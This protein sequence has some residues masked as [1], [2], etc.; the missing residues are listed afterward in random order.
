MS[1]SP[2][3]DALLSL[4]GRTASSVRRAR[5]RGAFGGLLVAAGTCVLIARLAA[6]AGLP[7]DALDAAH[8]LAAILIAVTAA[9]AFAWAG[10]PV[11]RGEAARRL[12]RHH[13]LRDAMASAAAFLDRSAPEPLERLHITRAAGVAAR[14]SLPR[15]T[16]PDRPW[17]MA[18]AVLWG[19]LGVWHVLPS[20][21]VSPAPD[22]VLAPERQTQSG[23]ATR[24]SLPVGSG[25]PAR[26]DPASTE[27]VD[28]VHRPAV[29][30]TSESGDAPVAPQSG[31]AAAPG[32]DGGPAASSLP[33]AAP[34]ANGG[35][36]GG[37]SGPD[38][39]A[40]RDDLARALAAL[41][42]DTA[43][44]R[45]DTASQGGV[46]L[47]P[48]KRPR[49]VES[50][51]GGS[52]A[53]RTHLAVD[54][55]PGAPQGEVAR[56]RQDGARGGSLPPPPSDGRWL[57]SGAAPDD[58]QRAVPAPASLG[59]EGG[60]AA[61]T[62]RESLG[63]EEGAFDPVDGPLPAVA[64]VKPAGE[65]SLPGRPGR[66]GERRGDPV[67]TTFERAAVPLRAITASGQPGR[68][69]VR[70]A[71][72]TDPALTPALREYAL[73]VNRSQAR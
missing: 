2:N 72:R 55:R 50:P 32:R 53:G 21:T 3:A 15:G 43:D 12:D 7:P 42:D 64:A 51:R 41:F 66:R 18:A 62:G 28:S 29:P 61:P 10:R 45:D 31:N 65:T 39:V 27:I 63:E 35:A 59:A 48:S 36:P 47:P 46:G 13:A 19:A 8:W 11:P 69:S 56:I 14:L 6:L 5:L 4:L 17:M 22:L 57:P 9:G 68:E 70:D 71:V 73:Y 38:A 49:R 25:P 16:V 20:A 37:P 58:V 26:P 40:A 33:A 1:V 34:G 52:E 44:R 67:P 23:D 60:A 30:H 54:D 24:A